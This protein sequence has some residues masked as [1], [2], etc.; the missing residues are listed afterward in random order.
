MTNP[1]KTESGEGGGED[2]DGLVPRFIK[3]EANLLRLPLFALHTKGLRSI[4]GIECRGR[5]NRDGV[6][7]EFVFRATR[8]TATSYPGPLART[9]HLAFL[10]LM[11]ERGFPL[12]NPITWSWRDLCR[13]MGVSCSGRTVERLKAAI[14]STR[15]L[16]ISSQYAIYAKEAGRLIRTQERDLG[17]YDEVAF[18]A[19]A[20]PD[21]DIADTN[22]L[23]L[24]KW[25]LDN[26]NAL[27]TAP[28]DYDLWRRLDE[29]SSIASRLY[30]FLLLNF[31][32]GA[33]VLRIGY[34]KLA[35]FLPVRPEKYESDARRQL[36]P[37]L[38]LL[39][40]L[41]VL[42]GVDWG[43][44]KAGLG[45]LHFRRGRHLAPARDR[46]MLPLSGGEEEFAAS[47]EVEEIRNPR[48]AEWLLVADF[49]RL[50][51]GTETHRPTKRELDQARDLIARH[52]QAKAKA[53]IHLVVKR[54]KAKWPDAKAFGATLKY[55][56][57]AAREY[58]GQQRRLEAE[59][60]ETARAE[61]ERAE[62]ER[63]LAER[64]RFEARWRP[65]WDGLPEGD[66]EAIRSAV[67][68]S[69]QFLAKMPRMLDHLCLEEL[70]RQRE[71][72]A[73]R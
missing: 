39:V 12:Q 38:D 9:A 64:E 11:T 49:Y 25:Y 21:G 10:S 55:L 1:Q 20:M 60:R 7:H 42:D 8:N 67:V 70:A 17:L 31:Y 71:T 63:E 62:Q 51:T 53:V 36:G 54:L 37:A 33:P 50:W 59:R 29:K 6:T 41:E 5:V 58:D 73:A 30:E 34:E 66:R 45:L 35:Q 57:D 52:G 26:L 43:K 16:M 18:V 24:S 2:R 61:A 48:P 56:D 46:E 27:F 65:A 32:S 4:D 44:A 3:A 15:G 69:N 19:E 68:S 14:R 13:R 40:S 72:G 47:V 23:W 22:H 28:L